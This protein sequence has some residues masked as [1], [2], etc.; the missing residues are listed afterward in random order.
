MLDLWKRHWPIILSLIYFFSP[1]DL[2]PELLVFIFGPAAIIDD[3]FIL[4]IGIGVSIYR[5]YKY[6]KALQAANSLNN[7]TIIEGEIVSR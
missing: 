5:E 3:G 7:K 4:T 1:I 2:I 6:R